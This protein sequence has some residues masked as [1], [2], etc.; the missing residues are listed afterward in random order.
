MR[1][2]SI[3]IESKAAVPLRLGSLIVADI[4]RMPYGCGTWPAF[5]TYGT[6]STWPAG[7]EIDILEGVNLQTHNQYTL[8]TSS[9]ACKI[10]PNAVTK[11]SLMPN[12]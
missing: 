7:G 2:N 11:S 3:R 12:K 10:D 6:Q 9:S 8:H 5:W 1:R 4:I